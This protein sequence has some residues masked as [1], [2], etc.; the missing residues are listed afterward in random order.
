MAGTSVMRTR[1][2]SKAIPTA[3]PR[4]IG[5]ID[6]EPSGTKAKKTK[7][8]MSAAAVTTREPLAKPRATDCLALPVLTNSSRMPETRK[9]S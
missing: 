6:P 4:A 3:S 8:M 7:N 9:T 1:K 5:L 2:A